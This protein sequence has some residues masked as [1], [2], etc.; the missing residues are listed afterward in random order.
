MAGPSAS[1]ALPVPLHVCSPAVHMMPTLHASG[2]QIRSQHHC[3]ML[4]LRMPES[5]WQRH[6][7]GLSSWPPDVATS[8]ARP[9]GS[10]ALLDAG[11][12]CSTLVCYCS[13]FEQRLSGS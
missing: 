2:C 5:L 7:T 10:T 11:C 4:G 12:N 9:R 1:S 6:I 8:Q 3:R 13:S